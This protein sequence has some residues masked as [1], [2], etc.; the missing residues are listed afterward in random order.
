MLRKGETI[1]EALALK[2][3]GRRTVEAEIF[4]FVAVTKAGSVH[5]SP[6]PHFGTLNVETI[7]CELCFN[8]H[9]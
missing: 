5:D 1:S 4:P 2:E 8:A 7:I 6:V 3:N 9:H